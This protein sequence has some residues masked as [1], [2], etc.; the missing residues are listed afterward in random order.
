M[1]DSGS[2]I[3]E[4]LR[5]SLFTRYA[6]EPGLEDGRYGV[7][8]GMVLIRST[9]AAHGGTVL[10]DHPDDCGTRITV[11]LAIRQ[12]DPVV[13]SPRFAIDY[14]GERDHGLIELSDVLPAQLYDPDTV[15]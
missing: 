14:A 15:N 11:S 13:R 8:L 1:C 12:G 9:A 3:A 4:N 5:G 2:G 10:I 7:G 6:R